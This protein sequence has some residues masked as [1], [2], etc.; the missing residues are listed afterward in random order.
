MS[1]AGAEMDKA[2]RSAVGEI[3]AEPEAIPETVEDTQQTEDAPFLVRFHTPYKFEGQTYIELDMSGLDNL[4]AKDMTAAESYLT[5]RGIVS[6]LPEMTLE[7]ASYIASIAT[8]QP[9][10][11]FK[12]LSP[13][14]A[15]RVKNMVTSYFFGE[16]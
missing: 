6:A 8:G 10:E 3:D 9:L 4:T 5:R 14:N 12:G 2:M 11:F 1:K 13:K 7:Y 15:I 16:G